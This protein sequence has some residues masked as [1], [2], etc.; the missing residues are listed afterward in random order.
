M[1][2]SGTGII[3][4]GIGSIMISILLFIVSLI[5]RKTVGKKIKEE[6]ER[7]YDTSSGGQTGY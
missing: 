2:I 4:V 1:E 7:E 5:Y 3:I 6:L